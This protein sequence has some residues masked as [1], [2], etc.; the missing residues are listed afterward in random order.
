[1]LS[2]RRSPF[3]GV[4]SAATIWVACFRRCG[5]AIVDSIVVLNCLFI[6]GAILLWSG[7][8]E[9]YFVCFYRGVGIPSTSRAGVKT[10]T[11]YC[12]IPIRNRE[13]KVMF[14][15]ESVVIKIKM[16]FD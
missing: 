10:K 15:I 3:I 7:S 14:V 9:E 5:I 2:K 12:S 4:T 6:L 8:F 11:H 16:D 1:M 13:P